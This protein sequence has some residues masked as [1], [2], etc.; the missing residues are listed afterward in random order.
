M[1]H[2]S[3]NYAACSRRPARAGTLQV[4]CRVCCTVQLPATGLC[5]LVDYRVEMGQL[6][7]HVDI[8]SAWHGAYAPLYSVSVGTIMFS[9]SALCTPAQSE[10]S[11]VQIE[12][13][14][15]LKSGVRVEK[16]FRPMLFCMSACRKHDRIPGSSLTCRQ[17]GLSCTL[18]PGLQSSQAR[19]CVWTDQT[20]SSSLM[21]SSVPN[22]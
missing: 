17:R 21:Q 13:L 4:T 5:Y 20:P 14:I 6:R 11:L 1:Q 7:A 10:R 18:L 12:D 16:A 3:Q 19:S 15:T 8:G 2:D 22:P 9:C